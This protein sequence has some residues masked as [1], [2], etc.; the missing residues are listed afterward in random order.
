MQYTARQDPINNIHASGSRQTRR[1]DMYRNGLDFLT[2]RGIYYLLLL[3]TYLYVLVLHQGSSPP[4]SVLTSQVVIQ[5]FTLGTGGRSSQS[6][7]SAG[8][9]KIVSSALMGTNTNN[10][11]AETII[12]KPIPVLSPV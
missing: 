1:Y 4:G 7:A 5:K 12:D 6:K 11:L 3:Y 2:L 10:S 8:A 9:K